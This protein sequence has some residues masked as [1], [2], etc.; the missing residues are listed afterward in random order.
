MVFDIVTGKLYWPDDSHINVLRPSY[1]FKHCYKTFVGSTMLERVACM[2]D[3][4]CSTFLWKN[5]LISIKHFL[6]HTTNVEACSGR[7]NIQNGGGGP[8]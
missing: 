7:F 1:T 2:L 3:D 8:K 4:V 5:A 6:Q